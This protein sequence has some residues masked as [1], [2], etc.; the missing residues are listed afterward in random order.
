MQEYS[1]ALVNK[2]EEKNNQAEQAMAVLRRANQ[3]LGALKESLERRVQERTAN[4]KTANLK[5]KQAFAEVQELSGLLPICAWCKKIRGLNAYW[6][7]VEDYIRSHAKA[8]FSHG[9]CP[10]CFEKMRTESEST[11]TNAEPRS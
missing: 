1:V 11:R 10:E 4:L 9:I 8:E 2:L 6:H 5:L 7:Q 3:V